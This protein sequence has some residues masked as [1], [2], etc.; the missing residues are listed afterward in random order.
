MERCKMDNKKWGRATPIWSGSGYRN[1]IIWDLERA[2]WSRRDGFRFWYMAQ[3]LWWR[4]CQIRNIT[5]YVTTFCNEICIY[6]KFAV[7]LQRF[8]ERLLFSPIKGMLKSINLLVQRTLKCGNGGYRNKVGLRETDTRRHEKQT[9][10]DTRDGHSQ[11]YKKRKRGYDRILRKSET[12]TPEGFS[13]GLR[14]LFLSECSLN[15]VI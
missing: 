1:G 2:A 7:S 12:E 3:N 15:M 14:P 9:L 10:A 5:I 8:S 13:L 6:K 11:T 4:I